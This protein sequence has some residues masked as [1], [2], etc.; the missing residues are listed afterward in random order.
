[1]DRGPSFWTSV[2][3]R[4]LPWYYWASLRTSSP[5]PI[6]RMPAPSTQRAT[7]PPVLG[8]RPVIPLVT[9]LGDP[10]LTVSLPELPLPEPPLPPELSLSPLSEPPPFPGSGGVVPPPFPS[11]L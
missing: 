11:K 2:T 9:P 1:M 10:L 6:S 5:P 8:S 4:S 7:P 3:N